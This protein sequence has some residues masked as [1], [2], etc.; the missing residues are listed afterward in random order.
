MSKSLKIRNQLRKWITSCSTNVYIEAQA[1]YYYYFFF[2][3]KKKWV[4]LME[5]YLQQTKQW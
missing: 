4:A 5:T 3:K 2:S 1:N